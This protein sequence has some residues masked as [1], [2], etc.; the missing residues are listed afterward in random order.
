M[1]HLDLFSGIGGFALAAQWVWGADHEVVAFCEIEKY[2]QRVLKKHWPEVHIHDDIKKLDGAA[3]AGIDVLTGG[4]PCQ[5]YSV[6]GKRLGKK[7]DRALW[8]E[9]LRV[10][11]EARPRWILGENVAGFVNMELD[12]VFS[13]LECAGYEARAVVVPACAVDAP[14]RRDRV[15]ILAHAN[16]AWRGSVDTKWLGNKGRNDADSLQGWEEVSSGSEPGCEA[17]TVANAIEQRSN[18]RLLGFGWRQREPAKALQD[19]RRRRRKA[20]GEPT[21]KSGLGGMV[22]G[23][24]NWVDEP[25]DVTRVS[26]G[27]KDRANRLRGLGNAIVPQ[28]AAVIMHYIKLIEE[29]SC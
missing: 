3:Y 26:V 4:F 5:P 22:D 1:R 25:I 18:W 13:D 21:T 6:A 11:T 15:W 16:D 8:P 23:I 2:A 29:A 17:R 20:N 12:A 19:G 28:V 7:D 9:M 14:H 24:S 10:I 27:K